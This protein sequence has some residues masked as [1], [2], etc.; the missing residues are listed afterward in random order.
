V[1]LRVLTL[2]T[3]FPNRA[4]PILGRF[5]ERQTLALAARGDVALEAVVP[6]GL[7]PWPLSL[8]RHYAPLAHLPLIESPNGIAVHRPRYRAWGPLA[9]AGTARRMAAALR[10][11][12][13][14]LRK[15]FPFD[16]IDAEY[17]WPDGPAAMHLSEALGVPFSVKARGSDIHHWG[18]IPGIR[19]QIVA[20]GRA[21]GGLLAVSE[22]LRRDMAALG[23]PEEKIRVHHT[24]VD[25]DSFALRDK[26]A[27]RAALGLRGPVF[28][29]V[30]ALIALK[31]QA[32]AIAAVEQVPDATLLIVGDGPYRRE[33]E[34]VAGP[35]VRFLGSRPHGEL[36]A[37]L[38][39]ADA[40]LLPSVS[41]G[42]ANVWVE[43][44]ACGT[45][46]VIGDVG[47]A[48]EV[49][50]SPDAGR[51]VPLDADAIAE[52]LREI[53]ASPPPPAEVRKAAE[54]FTWQRNSDSL[55]AHLSQIAGR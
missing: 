7:P 21:A 15:R 52:A 19:E 32:L 31:N 1:V 40:M 24:G 43:A 50:T 14:E 27:A 4:Q 2:T 38:A 47:G 33:L 10:R 25:L 49:V 18:A 55:Y 28:I 42:L 8:H 53:V 30:G 46:I 17:F 37:L 41:E 29:T 54:P 11:F 44:L 39:A 35:G 34:R 22:E 16:V 5:V 51:I 23:M 45:P 6:L 3:L 36:P 13:A 12:M 9:Q 20:A 48:R 26:A